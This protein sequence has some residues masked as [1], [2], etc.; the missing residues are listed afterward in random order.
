MDQMDT[1]MDILEILAGAYM[2]YCA[3]KMKKTGNV[4]NDLVSRSIDPDKAPDKEGYIKAMFLPD[5]VMG[6]LL[7]LCGCIS[8]GLPL[9][10]VNVP[11]LFNQL[12]IAFVLVLFI[13]YGVYSMKTQKQHLMPRN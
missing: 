11:E 4:K 1:L 13:I 8:S 9:I 3:V 6:I 12:L 5:I 2:I 10:G 7:I